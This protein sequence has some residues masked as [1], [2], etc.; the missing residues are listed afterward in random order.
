M[1]TSHTNIYIYIIHKQKH[2]GRQVV[3]LPHTH[4]NKWHTIL[5][6]MASTC[7]AR[8]TS[9]TRDDLLPTHAMTHS[10]DV[11]HWHKYRYIKTVYNIN[12]CVAQTAERD[13]PAW[14]QCLRYVQVNRLDYAGSPSMTTIQHCDKLSLLNENYSVLPPAVCIFNTTVDV[15]DVAIPARP[16]PT[17]NTTCWWS[18]YKGYDHMMPCQLTMATQNEHLR[19]FVNNFVQWF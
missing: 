1:I 10:Y 15:C 14:L 3:A 4:G 12:K 16:Q 19:R 13:F 8:H 6:R 17:F 5:H 11:Q 7:E 2:V 9:M 18:S